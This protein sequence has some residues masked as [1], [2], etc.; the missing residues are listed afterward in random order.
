M[1]VAT[2]SDWLPEW[3]HLFL[4]WFHI[5]AGIMW[6]GQT[7]FFNWMERT[8]PLTPSPDPNIAGRIWMVHGGGFY[9]VEKQK[10][11]VQMPGVLHWFKY[12]A[13]FSWITG[14]LLLG[15]VYWL[16]GL[17]TDPRVRE[18]PEWQAI[19]MVVGLLLVAWLVY[20]TIVQSP[21]GKNEV[22]VAAIG[23]P[24]IVAV[25]YGLS[26]LLS[27]RAAWMHVGA[28]F[29]TIMV[30]NVWMRILP[31]QSRM[32]AALAKGEAPDMSLGAKGKMRSKH[33]TYM[34]VPLI[35]IMIANHFPTIGFAADY[36]WVVLSAIILVGWGMAKII[37]DKL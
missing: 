33:N 36:P 32:I 17:L 20:D 12:E 31:N 24:L 21:I 16:G 3:I 18:L 7:W 4:R 27:A 26:Q 15:Q 28:M 34:S 29:G 10:V 5:I 25:A 8:F 11:P 37:R 19:A 2:V 35:L 9:H 14:M 1:L 6:L 30:A 22:A 13:L 23:F